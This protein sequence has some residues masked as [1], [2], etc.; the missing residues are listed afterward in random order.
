MADNVLQY[1]NDHQKSKIVLPCS[2]VCTHLLEPHCK[3]YSVFGETFRYVMCCRGAKSSALPKLL[4]QWHPV[5][6]LEV[7]LPFPSCCLT[8]FDLPLSYFSGEYL[9]SSLDTCL[10][11]IKNVSRISWAHV[12]LGSIWKL[13][14]RSQNAP[15]RPKYKFI[16]IIYSCA[17]QIVLETK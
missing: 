7:F 2:S 14:C 8:Y 12:P 4:M 5:M 9:S 10:W 16:T 17:Q 1:L 11:I 3:I 6:S 13:W 15:S